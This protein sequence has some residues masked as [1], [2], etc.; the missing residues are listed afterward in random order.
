MIKYVPCYIEQGP[1]NMT[2]WETDKCSD[3]ILD[4]E[5][6]V[7][8]TREEAENFAAIE[9]HSNEKDWIWAVFEADVDKNEDPPVELGPMLSFFE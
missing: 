3:M 2:Y 7:F 4:I 8:D 6:R 9:S 5:D 1:G